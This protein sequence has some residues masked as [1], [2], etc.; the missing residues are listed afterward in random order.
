MSPTQMPG[1]SALG[2]NPAAVDL[3]HLEKVFFLSALAAAL[4]FFIVKIVLDL[5]K[6]HYES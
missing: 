6:S 3:F 5:R 4:V 2:L 1:M